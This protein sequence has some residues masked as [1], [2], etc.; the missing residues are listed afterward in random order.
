MWSLKNQA[1]RF[2]AHL[3]DTDRKQLHNELLA[4]QQVL[5]ANQMTS[6]YLFSPFKKHARPH[7][8]EH[9]KRVLQYK[10][11]LNE[12]LIIHQIHQ[13]TFFKH[14]YCF[15]IYFNMEEMQTAFL[16]VLLNL[17]N[18]EK[19]FTPLKPNFINS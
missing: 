3:S 1:Q 10:N 16:D 5:T 6:F 8:S 17:L 12:E 14:T 18:E 13:Q 19:T 15:H 7:Y 4:V 9:R 11:G 2:I